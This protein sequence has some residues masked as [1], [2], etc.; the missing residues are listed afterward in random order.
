M[1]ITLKTLSSYEKCF[2]IV[3]AK[4]IHNF[5][6]ALNYTQILVDNNQAIII[7]PSAFV[8]LHLWT[9]LEKLVRYEIMR[10]NDDKTND[11]NTFIKYERSRTLVRSKLMNL[12]SV[13]LPTSHLD[14]N[15]AAAKTIRHLRALSTIA[16]ANSTSHF[17]VLHN[18]YYL[19]DDY[20][21]PGFHLDWTLVQMFIPSA[22]MSI[23]WVEESMDKITGGNFTK[24]GS[25]DT[26][27]A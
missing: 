15:Y 5:Y 17:N 7:P 11:N 27:Q 14:L 26:Q 18:K 2:Y 22:L 4:A 20:E 25:E 21:D 6:T 19:N 10:I 8:I 24:Y 9:T 16:D 13:D 1:K 12:V 3:S 23:K